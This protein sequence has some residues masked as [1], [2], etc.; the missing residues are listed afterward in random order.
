M[1]THADF[2]LNRIMLIG[3]QPG[4]DH[5]TYTDLTIEQAE[6]LA[7]DLLSSAQELRRMNKEC[8]EYFES[9]EKK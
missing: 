7:Q 9:E 5:A 3:E 6:S 1:K 8:Q 4:Q 2:C